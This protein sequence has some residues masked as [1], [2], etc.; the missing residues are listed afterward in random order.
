MFTLP[1]YEG[2]ITAT[3][4]VVA[5]TGVPQGTMVSVAFADIEV[6]AQLAIAQWFD[7]ASLATSP[8]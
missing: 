2:P 3:G 6:D 5:R 1:T 8:P 4:Y 7:E